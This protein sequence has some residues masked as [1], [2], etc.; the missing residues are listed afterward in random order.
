[1]KQV[2]DEVSAEDEGYSYKA[3]ILIFLG[4]CVLSAV[5][6]LLY[7]LF[8]VRLMILAVVCAAVFIKRRYFIDLFRQIKGV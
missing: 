7:E 2:I 4:L 1:M 6:A 5:G 3:L 8:L